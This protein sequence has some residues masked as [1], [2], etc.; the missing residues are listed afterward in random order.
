M[1]PVQAVPQDVIFRPPINAIESSWYAVQTLPRHEKAVV[2]HLQTENIDCFVPLTLRVHK[3]SDRDRSVSL[4][5]FPG[6][7][8]V[9]LNDY[10]GERLR[11]LRRPGVVRFVG[12]SQGAIPLREYEI[13]HI[14]QLRENKIHCEP[15]PYLQ[16]GQK[17]RIRNGALRGVEGILL[18][19]T[20]K[21]SLVL[22]IS[23]IQRSLSIR[24]EGYDVEVL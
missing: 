16:A 5:I 9:R 2:G 7:A 3:W 14:R 12:N 17:V 18:L 10:R 22:S 4:P 1:I 24:I 23:L 15:H 11:V 8:F 6:Y 19:E 20:G 21:D 13:E